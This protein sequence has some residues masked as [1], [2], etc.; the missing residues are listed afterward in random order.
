MISVRSA[1]ARLQDENRSMVAGQ[2]DEEVRV[3]KFAFVTLSLILVQRRKGSAL[4]G[5][6][7]CERIGARPMRHA[8]RPVEP[9]PAGFTKCRHHRAQ[10]WMH[11]PAVVA[12]IVIFA[13]RLPVGG[14]GIGDRVADAQLGLADS[15]RCAL[16]RSRRAARRGAAPL[17][18]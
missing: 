9:R 14:D 16:R 8:A 18:A 1:R 5:A 7:V 3:Y 15:A 6:V 11:A 10:L 13:D 17:P 4:G 2:A 12:L